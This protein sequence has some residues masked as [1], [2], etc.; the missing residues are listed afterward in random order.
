MRASVEALCT[1]ASV[2]EEPFVLLDLRELV[3]QTFNLL[4]PFQTDPSDILGL[5]TCLRRRY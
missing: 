1:V 2:E 4:T 3:S 5:R